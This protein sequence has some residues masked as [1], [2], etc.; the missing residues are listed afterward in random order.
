MLAQRTGGTK[1]W[2]C[3]I[4][5]RNNQWIAKGSFPIMENSNLQFVVCKLLTSNTGKAA[6][7]DYR[8]AEIYLPEFKIIYYICTTYHSLI[9][10]NGFYD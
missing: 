9:N 6:Q 1:L 10:K 3:L 2:Q 8:F 5:S 4:K 7:V